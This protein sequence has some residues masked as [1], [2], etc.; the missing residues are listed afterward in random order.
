MKKYY[1]LLL[2]FVALVLG[3]CNSSPAEEDE[4]GYIGTTVR[5]S[6]AFCEVGTTKPL[7]TVE[8]GTSYDVVFEPYTKPELY[9]FIGGTVKKVTYSFG[10]EVIGFST[11][12]P[13]TIQYT[14]Q[15]PGSRTLTAEVELK[16]ND[17][18][19]WVEVHNTVEVIE[20]EE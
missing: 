16:P 3:G 17:N 18:N 11:T 20:P 12:E 15:K 19:K 10:E 14:P 4:P 13:F 6:A 1:S 9:D 2:P 7:L 8:V 5:A